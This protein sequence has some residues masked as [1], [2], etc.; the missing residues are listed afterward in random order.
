MHRIALDTPFCV[1]VWPFIYIDTII[2]HIDLA[3]EV[4]IRI[5][6][7]FSHC[8][9]TLLS[10]PRLSFDNIFLQNSLFCDKLNAPC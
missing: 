9:D 7:V 10:P 4:F 2:E 6:F 8:R 5:S 3:A 1:F